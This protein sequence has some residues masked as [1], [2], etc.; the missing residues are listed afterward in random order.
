MNTEQQDSLAAQAWDDE[1]EA[2]DVASHFAV[3]DAEPDDE[4]LWDQE[5][6]W[7][8]YEMEGRA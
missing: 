4:E 6:Y 2:Q 8:R 1:L 3:I 7:L 5:L